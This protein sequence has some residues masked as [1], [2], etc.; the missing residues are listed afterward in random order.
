MKFSMFEKA[1]IGATTLLFGV[2]V[3]FIVGWV[4]NAIKI[5]TSFSGGF[6]GNEMEIIIRTAGV[7]FIPFGGVV[8]WF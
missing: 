5:I 1:G 6:S 2:V 3:A 7:I 4:L 8:G